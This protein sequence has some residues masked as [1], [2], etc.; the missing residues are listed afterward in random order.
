MPLKPA[1]A[2]ISQTG[3]MIEKTGAL[4]A[5]HGA[6]LEEVEPGHGGERDHGR[7]QGSVGDATPSIVTWRG[8][9]RPR[10]GWR[11]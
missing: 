2:Q 1:K 5:D 7:A 11:P 4:A 3:T 6:E 9:P 10:A 8:N